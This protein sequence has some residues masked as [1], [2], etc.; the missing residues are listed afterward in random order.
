M[1]DIFLSTNYIL[2]D[3]IPHLILP[4]LAGLIIIGLLTRFVRRDMNI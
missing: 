1:S 3:F 4:F 2:F